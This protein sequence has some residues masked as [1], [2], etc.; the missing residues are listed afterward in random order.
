MTRK[1]SVVRQAELRI[2]ATPDHKGIVL[3]EC[4]VPPRLGT[5]NDVQCNA[6]QLGL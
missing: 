3:V 1:K 2:L 6:H 5:G 4:E